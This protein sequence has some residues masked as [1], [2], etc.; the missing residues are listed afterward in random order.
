MTSAGWRLARWRR[1]RRIFHSVRHCGLLGAAAVCDYAVPQARVRQG[2]CQPRGEVT[3][4]H[5]KPA[6]IQACLTAGE[7]RNAISALAASGCV[8][9]ELTPATYKE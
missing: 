5:S 4:H 1:C 8:L 7:V 2:V 3:R 6:A 9:S